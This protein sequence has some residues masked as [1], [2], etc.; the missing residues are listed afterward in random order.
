MLV[1]RYTVIDNKKKIK[2]NQ[3]IVKEDTFLYV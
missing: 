3:D 1:E 2:K